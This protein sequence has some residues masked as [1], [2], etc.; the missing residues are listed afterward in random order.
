MYPEAAR[1]LALIDS[2]EIVAKKSIPYPAE[3]LRIPFPH[4]PR[5]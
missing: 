1:T 3:L 5:I 2:K 4:H